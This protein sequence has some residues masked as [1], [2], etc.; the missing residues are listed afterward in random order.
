MKERVYCPTLEEFYH[1][2][3]RYGWDI[4]PIF[5]NEKKG[6]I[7]FIFVFDDDMGVRLYLDYGYSDVSEYQSRVQHMTHTLLTQFYCQP[8]NPNV[9][10]CSDNFHGI[11]THSKRDF[12]WPH[13]T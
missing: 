1:K 11:P 4:D 6:I 7:W 13:Y 10:E 8:N 2:L 3:D 5:F 12:I 9:F